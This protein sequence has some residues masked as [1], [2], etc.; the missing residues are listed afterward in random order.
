MRNLIKLNPNWQYSLKEEFRYSFLEFK[1]MNKNP[2]PSYK[3]DSDIYRGN[4][5][6]DQ[7]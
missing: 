4:E 3:N 1:Y 5:G 6:K 2:L 7:P